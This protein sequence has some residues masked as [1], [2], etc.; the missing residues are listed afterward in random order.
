MC[1]NEK[2]VK[3]VRRHTANRLKKK[4]KKLVRSSTGR[5]RERVGERKRS[6]TREGMVREEEVGWDVATRPW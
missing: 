4:K 3:N 2:R 6:K 1:N 5:G